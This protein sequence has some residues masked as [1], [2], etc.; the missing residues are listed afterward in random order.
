M[1]RFVSAAFSE[2]VIDEG[3]NS[4]VIELSAEKFVVLALSS[5]AT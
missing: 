4:E 5:I 2:A 1:M 3:E